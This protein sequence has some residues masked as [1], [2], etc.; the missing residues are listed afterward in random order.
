MDFKN[1]FNSTQP[2]A[3]STLITVVLASYFSPMLA[4]NPHTFVIVAPTTP[5]YQQQQFEQT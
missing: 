5:G 4:S 3:A 1:K 2:D